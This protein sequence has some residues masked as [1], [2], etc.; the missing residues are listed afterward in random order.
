M[1][2]YDAASQQGQI[3]VFIDTTTLEAST[4]KA[5]ASAR[6]PDFFDVEK[7][8]SMDFKSTRFVFEEGKLKA[9]DGNLT[10]VGKTRPVTLTVTGSSCTTTTPQEPGTCRAAA[11]LMV[12]RSDFDMKAWGHSVGE[13]VTIRIAICAKQV[14]EKDKEREKDPPK[15]PAKEPVKNEPAAEATPAR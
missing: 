8:P 12:K 10:L 14:V 15:E 6:G 3:E 5:Q 1:L 2:V 13:M 11:E 7:H 9:V 4:E